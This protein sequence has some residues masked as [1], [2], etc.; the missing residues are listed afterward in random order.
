MRTRLPVWFKQNLPNPKIMATMKSLMD[1][2][3]LHTI[4]KSAVCP[5]IGECFS[6]KTATFLILG[7]VCTRNCTFCAVKKGEATLVDNEEPQH[8][9]EAVEKLGLRYV[10]ITSVTRDDLPDGG[11]SQFARTIRLLRANRMDM[12]VEVLIPDFLDC[13]G[14]VRSVVE[15]EPQVIN[16]NVETVPHLYQKVRPEADYRRSI[17]LLLS[18]KK[19]NPKVITK[20]GL[21]LGL[22]ETKD[23]VIRVMEDLREANCDLLTIGQYLQPSRK[24]HPIVRFVPPAEFA[25]YKQIGKGMGFSGVASAPLIRS[26]FQAAELYFK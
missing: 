13:A 9:L 5:N 22:G 24:H 19:L 11:A 2:L 12:V 14:A 6:Q 7:N 10:V 15:A 16:H 17:E 21:M 4:C 3:G 26:S 20:S 18:V 23:Q 25:G 8:V 1:G